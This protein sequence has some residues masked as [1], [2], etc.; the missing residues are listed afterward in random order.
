[1][2]NETK[3]LKYFKFYLTN[4]LLSPK[5]ERYFSSRYIYLKSF[6]H[7]TKIT[8][9][10]GQN[11]RISG[12]H[13]ALQLRNDIGLAIEKHNKTISDLKTKN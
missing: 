12:Y 10:S 6:L 1:M 7:P 2:I 11:L 9:V 5:Y 13:I 4:G 3:F 8:G